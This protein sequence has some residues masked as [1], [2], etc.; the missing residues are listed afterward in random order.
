MLSASP[1]PI[2]LEKSR[3]KQPWT[4]SAFPIERF[5]DRKTET[6]LK[7]FN[8]ACGRR[9]LGRSTIRE[10]SDQAGVSIGTVSN[11]L[12]APH[13]VSDDTRARVQAVIEQLEYRPSRAARSLQARRSYLIGYLLPP[14]D[15]TF[16]LDV[17]LHAL[18]TAA[19]KVSL[20]VALFSPK[21]GETEI[22]AYRRLIRS[23]DVDGFILSETNYRDPRIGL[24]AEAEFPFVTFGRALT[25][26]PFSWVDVD[27]AAGME[28][29]ADHLLDLGHERITLVAWP[30]G[31]ESGDDRVRGF[32]LALRRRGQKLERHPIVRSE[33]GFDHGLGIGRKLMSQEDPPKAIACVEDGLALGVMAAIAESGRKVG[34]EVAVTGFDD[35]APAR[36]ISP[37]LTSVRQPMEQV[38]TVLIETLIEGF[39]GSN[40]PRTA[41][42]R[43]EL[44]VRGSSAGA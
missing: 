36:L 42:L 1:G 43:P 8:P 26:H 15:D 37:G 30:E 14:A 44:I 12:N 2:G 19:G 31:S 40:Y 24:L 39:Q 18:V 21:A 20:E 22:D 25:D 35:S 4:L 9:N 17:F 11:V 16:A 27:G 38:A 3:E 7:R 33:N 29:V 6:A 32:Q 10:V 34:T 41:L 23:A 28:Q 13:L 5:Q